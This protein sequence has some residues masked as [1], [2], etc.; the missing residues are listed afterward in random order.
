MK[1]HKNDKLL[2]LLQHATNIYFQPPCN[3]GK[4]I[5]L[6]V[7]A[8]LL[9]AQVHNGY[10]RRRRSRRR[11]RCNIECG[12]RFPAKDFLYLECGR[13]TKHILLACS[14]AIDCQLNRKNG[15]RPTRS[16]E[17]S[18]SCSRTGYPTMYVVIVHNRSVG[19]PEQTQTFRQF[20]TKTITGSSN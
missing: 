16:I 3:S 20:R 15:K 10:S 6:I 2:P 17:F 14:L 9:I 7:N 18:R 13:Q 5:S 19:R 4:L 1:I 11:H 8:A 12:T